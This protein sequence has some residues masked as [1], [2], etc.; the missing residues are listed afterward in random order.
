MS[1]SNNSGA[2]LTPLSRS[3]SIKRT[4]SDLSKELAQRDLPEPEFL[5]SREHTEQAQRKLD[6][7]GGRLAD[8]QQDD[9]PEG[10]FNYMHAHEDA[11]DC[12]ADADI[13]CTT[14]TQRLSCRTAV[15]SQRWRRTPWRKHS[16]L[17][18]LACRNPLPGLPRAPTVP[19]LR[20]LRE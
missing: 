16:L 9:E 15:V 14:T 11:L 6:A 4:P 7:V 1:S 19:Q 20:V 12:R 18:S 17:S 10:E 5:R 3:G 13:S 8:L 2:T